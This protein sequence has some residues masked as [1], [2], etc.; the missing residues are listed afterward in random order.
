MKYSTLFIDLDGTLYDERTGLWDQI[1]MRMNDFMQQLL[2]LSL[3][4][5]ISLRRRYYVS[6]GT[7]LRGLQKHH[8]VDADAYL[9]Y[10][11]DIPLDQYLEPDPELH[12]LLIHLLQKKYIFTNA[13][14][15]HALRTL[16]VI[17]IQ[18]CFDGIIDVRALMYHCKPEPE[19]YRIALTLSGENDPSRALVIDDSER[20]LS[21]ARRAGLATVLV[22]AHTNTGV[23]LHVESIKD[24][25]R[26]LPELWSN[27]G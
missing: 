9:A 1:G 26:I 21:G 25:P 10:V 13:D 15:A 12:D 2:N 14:E 20:N 19:S 16:K 11:H 3:E 18:D 24:L 23:Y 4:E 8:D 27:D 5:T 6:Y 22:G 7:T 17:G